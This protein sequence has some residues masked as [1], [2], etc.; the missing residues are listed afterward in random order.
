M[1]KNILIV[2]TIG[3]LAIIIGGG[4]LIWSPWHPAV[5]IDDPCSDIQD[6]LLRDD[7]CSDIQDQLLRDDP[8]SDIQDQLLRDD[9]YWREASQ[10][11]DP[12]ICD[13]IQDQETID[14]CYYS[15]IASSNREVSVCDSIQDQDRWNECCRLLALSKGD[16]Y[17]CDSDWH[18]CD[19]D[20]VSPLSSLDG[21]NILNWKT[22]TNDFFSIKYPENILIQE[23]DNKIEFMSKER[24]EYFDHWVGFRWDV[25][26]QEVIVANQEECD[27]AREFSGENAWE[28][29]SGVDT[30]IMYFKIEIIPKPIEEALAAHIVEPD[31]IFIET[32]LIDS[33]KYA[34]VGKAYHRF[35]TYVTAFHESYY[36]FEHAPQS[37]MLISHIS[38]N[39]GSRAPL[40]C[41]FSFNNGSD[42]F[43]KIL[44]TLRFKK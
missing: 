29:K 9:C 30:P 35:R 21:L 26:G 41:E 42:L 13:K 32:L 28:C 24:D 43:I 40:E 25:I 15:Y 18:I 16:R 36:F 39:Y 27:F 33:A 5:P 17:F 19:P 31:N 7:P 23:S 11:R 8:C 4:L 3:V 44:S 6:Q 10:K 2:L 12:S 34:L 20:M 37:T 22:Y 14:N 1:N 38:P